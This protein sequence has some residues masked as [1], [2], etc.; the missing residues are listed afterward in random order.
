[1]KAN[2][3]RFASV[4]ILGLGML[5][6]TGFPVA[7][8]S[9]RMA[10]DLGK[11]LR[12]A[13]GVKVSNVGGVVLV[14]GEAESLSEYRQVNDVVSAVQET[15]DGPG[16]IRVRNRVKPSERAKITAVEFIERQIGSPEITVRAMGDTVLLEGTADSDFEAD[17]A[18]EMIT[19]SLRSVP[20]D[21][22][23]ARHTSSE[24]DRMIELWPAKIVDMLRIRPPSK[25]PR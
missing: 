14:E 8:G 15:S 4:G 17:R 16:A 7:N 21:R 24:P 22:P 5:I 13:A 6:G 19:T 1:M 2:R 20:V 23:A 3:S 12:F 9:S 25:R 18:I 11:H 10:S